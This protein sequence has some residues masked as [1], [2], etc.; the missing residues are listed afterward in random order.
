MLRA[1]VDA[2]PGRRVR[3]IGEPIRPGRSDVEYPA[4]VQHEVLINMTFA[5]CAA[6]ILCPYDVVGLDPAVVADAHQL[7]ART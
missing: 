6:T 2:R 1:A 7:Q 5:D 4:C 3:V